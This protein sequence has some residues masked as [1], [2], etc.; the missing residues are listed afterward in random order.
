MENFCCEHAKEALDDIPSQEKV[1]ELADFFKTFGDGSRI[2]LLF[3]L[4]KG[5]LCVQDLSSIL[6]MQQSAVSHQL[7]TLKSHKIIS[8]RREGKKTFYKLNDAHI[9]NILDMGLNHITHD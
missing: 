5:D 7:K 4:K 1:I 9:L 8:G 2:K 6:G 3:A